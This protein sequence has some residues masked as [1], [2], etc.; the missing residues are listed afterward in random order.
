MGITSLDGQ[1]VYS[2]SWLVCLPYEQVCTGLRGERYR[3]SNLIYR[4]D[5]SMARVVRRLGRATLSQGLTQKVVW[6]VKE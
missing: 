4:T 1:F 5:V 6:P 2:I 3:A